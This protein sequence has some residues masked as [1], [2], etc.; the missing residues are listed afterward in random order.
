MGASSFLELL[1]LR[2]LVDIALVAIVFYNLL[3]LIRGTRAVQVLLGLVFFG[4]IY[5]AAGLAELATLETILGQ[6]LFFLPFAVIVLFQHEIRRGLANFGRNPLLTFGSHQLTE[7]TIHEVV[8]AA[9][10]LS[11]RRTGALIVLQRLEGLRNYVENGIRIDSRVSYDL[12]VNVFTP[13][14]PLHDGAV[15]IY[16]NRIAAAACFLPVKLDSEV[17]TE[18]GTRH[19]AAL[20]ISSES[21]ALAVVVSEETGAISLGVAGE[22]IRDLDSKA[23]RNHLY[24]YLITELGSSDSNA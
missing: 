10:A 22:L 11:T 7:T 19:R 2:D 14:T 12:L 8:L 9:S 17:S 20:G 15:I 13:G 21:D 1:T 4:G 16:D 23:L 6:L 5:W 18:F 24:R 3:L